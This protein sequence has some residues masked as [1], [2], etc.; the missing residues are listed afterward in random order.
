MRR[1]KKWLSLLLAVTLTVPQVSVTT[2]ASEVHEVNEEA[3]VS[4]EESEILEV[5][6]EIPDESVPGE[7]AAEE[8]ETADSE[9]EPDEPAESAP[10]EETEESAESAPEEETEE[11]AESVSEEAAEEPAE[12]VPEEETA[13]ESAEKPAESVSEE[14]AAEEPD[15]SAAGEET[16]EPV[17]DESFVAEENEDAEE[18]AALT[19]DEFRE[20]YV[21][22]YQDYSKEQR[23]EAYQEYELYLKNLTLTGDIFAEESQSG[24]FANDYL[25]VAVASDGKFT[26]G[27]IEGNPNYTTDNG[28]KLLFGHPSPWSSETL[29]KVGE[30]TYW[31]RADTISYTSRSAVAVMD[32]PNRNVKVVQT[33]E[34]YR[35]GNADFEDTIR[36]SYKAINQN[37]SAIP[38]G[39]RIMLDTMLANN[40]DAPFKIS[41]VGNVTT[42][43]N[44]S[45]AEVPAAYQVYDNLDD[46]SV[47]A[48]GYL[49]V[50]G[51]RSPDRVQFTNWGSING[52]GWDYTGNV[53][54]YLGD[55]AVG[56]I[57][58]PTPVSAGSS[59]TVS[60]YYGVSVGANMPSAPGGQNVLEP[61]QLMIE[62]T[63][64]ETGEKIENAAIEFS[65]DKESAVIS[66]TTGADGISV[67]TLS[68]KESQWASIKVS[69]EGYA[70]RTVNQTISGGSR[71]AVTLKKEGS[72]VP[73]I[74]S[75]TMDGAD[76]LSSTIH[77]IEDDKVI[78]KDKAA[79]KVQ[80]VVTSDMDNCVYYLVQD[81]KVLEKNSTGVFELK[82]S[83]TKSGTVIEKFKSGQNRYVQCV[84]A[85]GKKS[86]KVKLGIKVSMPTISTSSVLDLDLWP[87]GEANIASG[88]M[89][90]LFLGDKVS[91]GLGKKLKCNIEVEENGMV[92]VSVNMKRM[93]ANLKERQD[94]MDAISQ[95]GLSNAIRSKF[96]LI[97]PK[98]GMGAVKP[99]FNVM[100]YGEG[101]IVDGHAQINVAIAVEGGIDLTHT[102]NFYYV[103]PLY[104]TVGFGGKISA[105]IKANVANE[106]GWQLAVYSGTISP[107][108][109][110][111]IEGGVGSK[112]VANLGVEGKGTL[113]YTNN[114][115]SKQ[116]N[117]SLTGEANICF[118]IWKFEKKLKLAKATIKIYDSNDASGTVYCADEQTISA[119]LDEEDFHLVSRDYLKKLRT[120][121]AEEDD[122]MELQVLADANPV[123]VTEGGKTYRFW[124]E[125]N[126]DENI[127]NSSQLVYA[128]YENGFWSGGIP[129]EADG[130]SDFYPAVAADGVGHIYI[131]WQ[132]SKK[133]FSDADVQ[134]QDVADAAEI[135]LAV[136][137]TSAD[138]EENAIEIYQVTDNAYMDT[139]PSVTCADGRVYIAWY[140][141][142][143]DILKNNANDY[144]N[145]AAFD[146]DT[147]IFGNTVRIDCNGKYVSQISAGTVGGRATVTYTL[148]DELTDTDSAQEIYTLLMDGSRVPE[149]LS[150]AIGSS[151][152]VV[153]ASL[154]GENAI[155]WYENNNIWYTTNPADKSRK[156]A[157]FTLDAEEDEVQSTISNEFT[158]T[159]NGRQTA[160]LWK[161][162][163]AEDEYNSHKVIYAAS[164]DGNSWGNPYIIKSVYDVDDLRRLSAEMDEEGNITLTYIAVS[165]D[166]DGNVERSIMVSE[167]ADSFTDL[168]L[169]ELSCD[170]ENAARG[171]TLPMTLL[172]QNTGNTV[173]D[174]AVVNVRDSYGSDF[175]ETFE[176]LSLRPG[177]TKEILFTSYM[178]PQN[179]NENDLTTVSVEVTADGDMDN[180]NGYQE[181]TLGYASLEMYT[182]QMTIVGGEEYYVLKLKNAGRIDAEDVRVKVLAD[183]E[184]GLVVLDQTIGTLQ[185]QEERYIYLPEENLKDSYCAYVYVT[186]STPQDNEGNEFW[187]MACSD[188]TLQLLDE[189]RLQINAEEGGTIIVDNEYSVSSGESISLD[190]IAFKEIPL[191]ASA[192]EGY[193]FDGWIAEDGILE[194]EMASETVFIMPNTEETKETSVTAAFIKE[195]DAVSDELILDYDNLS[196]QV[197]DEMTLTASVKGVST[198]QVNWT[199]D[200]TETVTVDSR[201]C[202]KAVSSGQA[203]VTACLKQNPDVTA[204][205]MVTVEDIKITDIRMVYPNLELEGKGDTEVLDILVTPRNASEEIE[206]TSDNEDIATVDGNGN[207]TAIKPGT[208]EIKAVSASGDVS[209][210]CKVMVVNLLESI[211][212]SDSLLALP[213]GGTG[214]ITVSFSPEDATDIS[215]VVWTNYS[216][217]LISVESSG[218]YKKTAVITAHGVGTAT[219]EANVNDKVAYCTIQIYV[220][221]T[222]ISISRTNLSL[223]EGEGYYLS[224]VMTP[225][226]ASETV[227]WSSDNTSVASVDENGYVLANGTGTARITASSS[228]SGKTA[229]CQVDVSERV[230]ET[231]MVT[232]TNGFE[233]SH[234]YSNNMDKIW[235]Y[236]APEASGIQL[237]F[238]GRTEFENRYDKL[239]ILNQ[240]NQ[241]LYSY[242]GKELAGKTITVPTNLVK[243]RVV[244][245]NSV[246]KWG[247]K[248]TAIRKLYDLTRARITIEEAA[249][250]TGSAIIPAASVSIGNV[251][252]VNG[253]DYTLSC[254][255]NVEVG[256]AVMTA[257]AIAP[258]TGSCR[259]S[260]PILYRTPDAVRELKESKGTTTS[261]TIS[262]NASA[263]AT[264]YKIYKY[265]TSKKKYTLVKTLK[266]NS[267]TSYKISKLKA[268]KKYKYAVKAYITAGGKTTLSDYTKITVAAA[269]K[270]PT[271]KGSISQKKASLQ[272]KKMSGADGYEIYMSTSKKG[273]YKKV[274]TLKKGSSV[275]TTV[276]K[277]GS[278]KGKRYFKIRSYTKA[279][280][281]KVYSSYSK[282]LT[283]NY[284]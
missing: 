253:V 238:D 180:S 68:D 31:F 173:I 1:G 258:N 149:P 33:L 34:L 266:G 11:S 7:E 146:A 261:A 190:Y 73:D 121:G 94:V 185:G 187:I 44:Y 71:I 198:K 157:I 10:E 235:Q 45:G 245:D 128:V 204:S 4:E 108:V 216:P 113:K 247:F 222:A 255:N 95:E 18:A 215:D 86:R 142:T 49:K 151:G 102:T 85:S 230:I 241:E 82:T 25:E 5:K 40:D 148:I 181:V 224:A 21:E 136:L 156:R 203:V 59:M 161:A 143:G 214:N 123:T 118:A 218:D 188:E 279:S 171:E 248:V 17:A 153:T 52:S 61:N 175:E 64:S 87:Y 3:T 132:D 139:L 19:W 55:S 100:G 150:E 93:P 24:S 98:V 211:S 189:G 227:E 206:W 51:E 58:D 254:T 127:S 89:G 48:T 234:N 201:G 250:Y 229:V 193:V 208:A 111:S 249:V 221:C 116:S 125:D 213:Q 75:A 197:G 23:Y 269:T 67:L 205:C 169:T 160:V 246:T 99:Y 103:V 195:E 138:R 147:G 42:I 141:N 92:K 225:S 81:E 184:D 120:E 274:A 91:F 278:K 159:G 252:L 6:E 209:A 167:Q 219:L 14:E 41:G 268:G 210:V 26:I 267:K 177:E 263:Y 38:V 199:S 35:S 207:V 106:A 9:K 62:V 237:T 107:E 272:W 129:V 124:L 152:Q 145:Y 133:A 264:G 109:H 280:S 8:S 166:A 114:F 270:A 135:K 66:G 158:V 36:I 122:D 256:T 80:L 232:G 163:I 281:G 43:T 271:L 233:T 28:V 88:T 50:S 183:A 174:E 276:K 162:T 168:C 126:G 101:Y 115:I 117:A 244:T 32:I 273:S 275:K 37:D 47:I 112:G 46:P 90:A 202:L 220:P 284:K 63:D 2:V 54:S 186:S 176:G 83:S 178:L 144:M 16:V 60:T 265:D 223:K 236:A 57:F 30:S 228:K 170:T 65:S 164:Y 79:K 260:F 20:L 13:E 69:A 119:L 140:S 194:D 70:G 15:T 283:L 226:N 27:N 259:I 182:D 77:Y 12:S 22:D 243:I 179:L 104:I 282:I 130:T 192:E 200:D 76:V 262:W 131:A 191:T 240:N 257:A 29:L 165:Y 277:L 231:V 137:D 134:V 105:E 155:F 110:A 196:L 154:N 97:Q 74:L 78:E 39:V 72:S 239:Y 84:S 56:I 96:Q 212:L 242:T 217:E 172:V 251:A 53:G